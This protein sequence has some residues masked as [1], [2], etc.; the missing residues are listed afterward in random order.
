MHRLW[1]SIYLR[2]AGPLRR[3]HTVIPTC[4]YLAFLPSILLV[5][6]ASS[7]PT[8]FNFRPES[9]SISTL[10]PSVLSLCCLYYDITSSEQLRKSG[11]CTHQCWT[12]AFSSQ[13]GM[14]KPHRLWCCERYAG[15]FPQCSSHSKAAES[16]GALFQMPAAKAQCAEAARVFSMET[17][18]LQS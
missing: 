9:D 11:N 3:H 10:S 2:V 16:L 7:L 13:N 4:P 5:S 1:A 12:A 14:G 6:L 15:S 18:H 8:V 17:K